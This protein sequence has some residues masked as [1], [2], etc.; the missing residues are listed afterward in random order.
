[1]L[2][3][4][5][6]IRDELTRQADQGKNVILIAHSYAG[7]LTSTA[8][9]G[10]SVKDRAAAGKKGG[11][12]GVPVQGQFINPINPA[13]VL[14]NDLANKPSFS[15]AVSQ[16]RSKTKTILSEKNTFQPWRNG[17]P[18]G[19]LCTTPDNALPLS[20]EQRM[21]A[22]FPA[23]VFKVKIDTGHPP[24]LSQPKAM[25]KTIKAAAVQ[26]SASK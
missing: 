4:A 6:R 8:V 18:V 25:A 5:A 20:M 17:I 13:Y 1:M 19:Y 10:L 16:L 14:Y 24:F 26:F 2:E 11:V 12:V 15:W 9:A 3:D 23:E 22:D 21:T 7:V